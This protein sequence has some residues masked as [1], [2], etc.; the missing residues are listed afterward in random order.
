MLSAGTKLMSS[1]SHNN[2]AIKCLTGTFADTQGKK[3]KNNEGNCFLHAYAE[4]K[5]K[6]LGLHY[7]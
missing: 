6:N 2:R 3:H 5:K 4:P 7:Y 1:G